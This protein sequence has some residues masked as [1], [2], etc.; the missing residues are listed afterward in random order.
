MAMAGRATRS[1]DDDLIEVDEENDLMVSLPTVR[2]CNS[3]NGQK[4]VCEN[5]MMAVYISNARRYFNYKCMWDPNGGM[6]APN[7]RC[8]QGASV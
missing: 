6:W 7:G 8:F 2:Y 1:E 3:L 5:S 4:S